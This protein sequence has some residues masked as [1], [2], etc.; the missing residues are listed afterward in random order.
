MS[1]K[2]MKPGFRKLL[3]TLREQHETRTDTDRLD[4]LLRRISGKA[5][6]DIGVEYS[7]GTATMRE[8]ID[9]AMNE[10]A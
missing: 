10:D 8:A 6:R 5:L 3:R 9:K 4:W 2:N 1:T 7:G